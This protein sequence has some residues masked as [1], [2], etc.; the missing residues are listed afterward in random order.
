M[1]PLLL[2]LFLPRDTRELH[3]AKLTIKKAAAALCGWQFLVRLSITEV[4]LLKT[5]EVAS[6]CVINR[7]LVTEN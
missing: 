3:Y 5:M 7:V 2:M 6:L 1:G 4:L